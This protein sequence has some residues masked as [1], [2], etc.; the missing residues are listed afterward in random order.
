ML[1]LSKRMTS[2]SCF[3][4]FS[5]M[6]RWPMRSSESNRKRSAVA[7]LHTAFRVRARSGQGQRFRGLLILAPTATLA[8]QGGRHRVLHRIV[9]RHRI[10]SVPHSPSSVR[11]ENFAPVDA[12]PPRA[13][14]AEKLLLSAV[15]HEDTD[16][17]C[18]RGTA[19]AR[20]RG[21]SIFG[22]KY[23]VQCCKNGRLLHFTNTSLSTTKVA[24]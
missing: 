21:Q 19:H 20:G 22:I 10:A 23:N 4:R 3:R 14:E 24:S 2:R 16:Y 15:C 17:L 1:R 9:R 13:I 18:V 11:E 12:T 7:L 6:P 8:K 5:A